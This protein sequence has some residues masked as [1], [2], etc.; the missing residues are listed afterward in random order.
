MRGFKQN[1]I[2][3]EFNSKE[4][5]STGIITVRSQYDR[6]NVAVTK[7]E[8]VVA[9]AALREIEF[10]LVMASVGPAGATGDGRTAANYPQLSRMRNLFQGVTER[11]RTDDSKVS[12]LTSLAR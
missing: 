2:W 3:R 9:T 7:H 6:V 10:H 5:P 4:C 12:L 8:L 1:G 11:L